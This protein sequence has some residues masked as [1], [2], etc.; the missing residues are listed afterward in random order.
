MNYLEN[1]GINVE[2]LIENHRVFI[3]NNKLLLRKQLGLKS[4]KHDVFTE[5]IN[6]ISLSYNDDERISSIDALETY[7]HGMSKDILSKR[8]K[9]KQLI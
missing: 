2:S 7:P 4:E 9:I 5:E 1:K 3:E 6:K 8:E